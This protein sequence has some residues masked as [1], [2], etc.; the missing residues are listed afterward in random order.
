MTGSDRFCLDFAKVDG[1]SKVTE[2]ENSD[3]LGAALLRQTRRGHFS[4]NP[5]SAAFPSS[6]TH[7]L[8]P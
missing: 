6:I 1:Q 4:E 3:A 5:E 8:K 7:C 2:Q